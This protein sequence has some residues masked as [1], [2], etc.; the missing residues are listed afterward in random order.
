MKLF[1]HI[2]R[3][4]IDIFQ[5][6]ETKNSNFLNVWAANAI[7]FFKQ[8]YFKPLLFIKLFKVFDRGQ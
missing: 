6:R 4:E 3:K 8:S 2:D 1:A 5:K 7:S